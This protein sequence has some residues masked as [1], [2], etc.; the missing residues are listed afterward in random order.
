[1]GSHLDFKSTEEMGHKVYS[2]GGRG[3][4]EVRKTE[5][6]QTA[7]CPLVHFILITKLESIP[8]LTIFH[9]SSEKQET[10]NS[11]A[12]RYI[13]TALT[14]KADAKIS[15]CLFNFAI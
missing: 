6:P 11:L 8:I 7:P 10:V 2:G 13:C 12:G 4:G 14:L 5:S 1:M 3:G 9:E 15:C